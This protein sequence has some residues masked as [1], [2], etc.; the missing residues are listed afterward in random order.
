MSQKTNF[1]KWLNELLLAPELSEKQL[2][3]ITNA[4]DWLAKNPNAHLGNFNSLLR[5]KFNGY[6]LYIKM[7]KE[8]HIKVFSEKERHEFGKRRNKER[9][10]KSFRNKEFKQVSDWMMDKSLL[11]KKP[12]GKTIHYE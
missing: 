7:A 1:N 8:G 12:S 4:L 3:Q 5:K 9:F 6:D 10:L 2:S 11:P